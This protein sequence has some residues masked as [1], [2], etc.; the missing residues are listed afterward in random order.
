M[1]RKAN[2]VVAIISIATTMIIRHFVYTPD[3]NLLITAATF[4]T[5]YAI[6]RLTLHLI[7]QTLRKQ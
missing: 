5:I 4:A 2:I 7:S 1:K 6:I 3:C